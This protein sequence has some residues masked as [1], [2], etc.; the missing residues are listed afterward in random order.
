MPVRSS[1]R[2]AFTCNASH[3]TF[4]VSTPPTIGIIAVAGSPSTGIFGTGDRAH[5]R[6]GAVFA[7]TIAVIRFAVHDRLIKR[8]KAGAHDHRVLALNVLVMS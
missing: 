4:V 3:A 5:H 1:R 7:K 8:I 2:C 6:G